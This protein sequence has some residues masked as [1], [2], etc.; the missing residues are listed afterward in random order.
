MEVRTHTL[1]PVGRGAV[2]YPGQGLFL[3]VP[4]ISLPAALLRVCPNIAPAFKQFA[5]SR[6]RQGETTS[7]HTEQHPQ[8]HSQ[9]GPAP[10]PR[11]LEERMR[12][13]GGPG[14]PGDRDH[15]DCQEKRCLRSV[16]L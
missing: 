12:G 7:A 9:G 6:G 1:K 5:I 11:G 3:T 15:S 13:T 4:H 16:F 2:L 10:Q 8:L 14:S